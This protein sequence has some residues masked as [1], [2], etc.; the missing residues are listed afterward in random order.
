MPT[1]NQGH[2]DIVKIINADG[3]SIGVGRA[4]Y[5]CEKALTLIGKRNARPMIHYDYLYLD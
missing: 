3:R 4:G 1:A 5:D 2:N